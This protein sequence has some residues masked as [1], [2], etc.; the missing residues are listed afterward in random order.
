MKKSASIIVSLVVAFVLGSSIFSVQGIIN[1][2]AQPIKGSSPQAQP[3]ESQQAQTS[4]KANQTSEQGNGTIVRD[5][6]TILL[7]G[8]HLPHGTFTH[9]Y[10]STPYEITNGHIAAKLPCD[11]NNQTNVKILTGSAPN[12]KVQDTEFVAPL[13][14]PGNLCMYHVDINSTATN[15]V[16]DIAIQNNSTSGITFPATSSV[17][18]G[19]NGIAPLPAEHTTSGTMENMTMPAG[20]VTSSTANATAPQ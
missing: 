8:K 2:Q 12:L 14:E 6:Q 9:L 18:I 17:V 13:S 19:V 20:N 15:P 3:S 11:D 5:S 16:T 10:D 1:A 7:E 4:E